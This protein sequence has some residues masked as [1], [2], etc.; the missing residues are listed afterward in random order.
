[1]FSSRG[2]WVQRV[3]LASDPTAVVGLRYGRK[4]RD[5]ETK[6]SGAVT[7]SNE[8]RSRDCFLTKLP[9]LPPPASPPPPHPP[10]ASPASG[11]VIRRA[12]M[13]GSL[14]PARTEHK[15]HSLGRSLAPRNEAHPCCMH[16]YAVVDNHILVLCTSTLSTCGVCIVYGQTLVVSGR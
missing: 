12:S 11:M 1:M 7:G 4:A 8:R 5:D 9:P 2:G 10:T 15:G 3:Q 6:K 16:T 13:T 14:T